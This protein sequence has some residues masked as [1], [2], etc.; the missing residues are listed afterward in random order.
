MFSD[1]IGYLFVVSVAVSP[2]TGEIN[3]KAI[4]VKKPPVPLKCSMKLV[5]LC[6][7][8]LLSHLNSISK[9]VEIWFLLCHQLL[10]LEVL[11][12]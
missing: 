5:S 6:Q 3:L 9:P 2:G 4:L 10:K 12:S 7:T 8:E 11:N 1:N